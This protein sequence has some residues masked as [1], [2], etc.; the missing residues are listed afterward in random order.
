MWYWLYFGV[1][2]HKLKRD[3]KL[4]FYQRQQSKPEQGSLVRRESRRVALPS[5]PSLNELTSEAK[6]QSLL[7]KQEEL[8]QFSSARDVRRPGIQD[9]EGSPIIEKLITADANDSYCQS[10]VCMK[11]VKDIFY[12]LDGAVENLC[13][14]C[15][16]CGS[17]C[18]KGLNNGSI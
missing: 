14:I 6:K 8:V 16:V 17:K 4:A 9:E 10:S 7:S 1:G 18:G 2:Y 15:C 13:T 11:V 5:R 3:G 12:C